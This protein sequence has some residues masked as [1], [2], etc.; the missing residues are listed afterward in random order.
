MGQSCRHPFACDEE[1]LS[2]WGHLRSRDLRHT[3]RSF[4]RGR[5]AMDKKKKAGARLGR[6]TCRQNPSGCGFRRAAS[7]TDEAGNY[8]RLSAG[9]WKI[10]FCKPGH[11]RQRNSWARKA[12]VVA[13]HVLP[14]NVPAPALLRLEP[15]PRSCRP[16]TAEAL[17]K[18]RR[19]PQGVCSLRGYPL[20][21]GPLRGR[22]LRGRT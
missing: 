3:H 11:K 2:D 12:R 22:P 13:F 14:L 9:D 1:A 8:S 6:G 4:L 21:G 20:R 7:R 17:R 16:G 15:E 19:R 18:D 5:R 10:R